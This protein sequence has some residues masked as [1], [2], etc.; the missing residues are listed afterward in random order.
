M[1]WTEIKLAIQKGWI[2][3]KEELKNYFNAV[4]GGTIHGNTTFNGSVVL[5]SGANGDEGG[6]VYFKKSPNSN[7]LSDII[8]D[9]YRNNFR[10]IA[11]TAEGTK[12]WEIQLNGANGEILN[13]GNIGNYALLLTGGKIDGDLVVNGGLELRL[14]TPYIDFHFAGDNTSDYTSRI[15]EMASGVLNVDASLLVRGST[16]LHTGNSRPVIV[17][18]T[19]PADTTAVWIVPS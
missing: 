11:V 9:T 14:S 3:T 2:A 8:V 4:T 16:V 17:S 18:A 1:S 19:A 5:V 10:I 12:T 13:A 15:I 7:L 6:E